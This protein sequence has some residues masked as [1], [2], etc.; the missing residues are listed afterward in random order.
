[1]NTQTNFKIMKTKLVEFKNKDKDILRGILSL[2][3]TPS[4]KAVLMCGGFER[5]A[6]TEKKFKA[7]TDELNKA[8]VPSLRFDYTG[9]GLSDGEFSKVSVKRMGSELQKAIKILKQK[10]KSE[11]VIIVGHSLSAC[12]IAKIL[13]KTPITKI[14]LLAP[15]LNQRELHKFWFVGSVTKKIDPL[16]KITWQNYKEHLDEKEFK[17]DLVRNDKMTKANYIDNNYFLENANK[18]YSDLF[19]STKNILVI[20]GDADD[21][22]P[23]ASLSKKFSPLI[24]QNG[25]HDL[26][27]PDMIEQWLQKTIDF[28]K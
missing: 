13:N 12:V 3:N 23:L 7:L 6:T 14:I 21:K 11:E 22:V 9:C 18:D 4:S 8:N 28:I 20:H 16:L 10:T 24:I 2:S 25:D 5:S 26:E 1:M 27:R 19:D 15:A 17:K